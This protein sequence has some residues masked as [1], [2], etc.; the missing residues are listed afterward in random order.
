MT[1]TSRRAVLRAGAFGVVVAPFA[2][3]RTAFAAATTNLYT[4]SRFKPLI[5][6]TFKLVDTTGSWSMT[7][8]QVNDLPNAASGDNYRFGLTFRSSAAG[9]PQ[10]TYTLRRSGFTSTTL[11]VVPSDASRRTYQAVINRA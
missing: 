1:E 7:L 3:V 11:F 8:S 6:A 2:S 9:P 4:R 10:G 5:N